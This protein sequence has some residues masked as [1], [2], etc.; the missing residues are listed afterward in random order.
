MQGQ[1]TRNGPATKIAFGL[2]EEVGFE[3]EDYIEDYG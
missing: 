2:K 3:Y 1:T